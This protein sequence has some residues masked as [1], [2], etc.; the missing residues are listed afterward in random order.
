MLRRTLIITVFVAGTVSIL[1]LYLRQSPE[2]PTLKS[3]GVCETCVLTTN[4]STQ[5]SPPAQITVGETEYGLEM[6]VINGYTVER[7]PRAAARWNDP[8]LLYHAQPI[9]RSASNDCFG[10]GRNSSIALARAKEDCERYYKDLKRF[11][12]EPW[13]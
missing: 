10:I 6:R 2:A 11:T 9:D 12:T 5:V 1:L 13:K 4:G 3:S 8:E 7:Q